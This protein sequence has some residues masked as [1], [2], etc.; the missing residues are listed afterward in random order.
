MSSNRWTEE[1]DAYLLVN[2]AK[3]GPAFI[4]KVTGRSE[5]AVTSRFRR[6]EKETLSIEEEFFLSRAKR[7]KP[8][9]ARRNPKGTIGTEKL[10]NKKT[11]KGSA[12]AHTKTGYRPD[13]D[14]VVRSGWESDVLRILKSYDIKYEFE[15]RV[16]T[17]PVKRGAKSYLPDIYLPDFDQYIE[18]KGWLDDKSRTKLRRFKRHY[19]HEFRNFAMIIGNSKK[20]KDLCEELDVPYVL[21]FNKLKKVYKDKI[22]NWESN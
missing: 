22:P 3:H 7:V 18:V 13:L 16:F 6:L 5:S 10:T 8:K 15:P 19:P 12:Y 11:T 2:Y 21:E 9:R 1:E 17:F 4:S 14:L 20:V